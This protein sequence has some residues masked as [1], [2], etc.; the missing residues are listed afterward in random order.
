MAAGQKRLLTN[1]L[2]RIQKMTRRHRNDTATYRELQN[3]G[4]RVKSFNMAVNKLVEYARVQAEVDTT[5]HRTI[6]DIKDARITTLRRA[7]N[8][9]N[10]IA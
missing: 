6:D 9:I 4:D 3:Y 5:P 10:R 7:I 1:Q 8:R 2:G